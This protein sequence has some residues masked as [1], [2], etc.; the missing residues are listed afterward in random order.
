MCKGNYEFVFLHR[1][2]TFNAEAISRSRGSGL[3]ED[4]ISP[5]DKKARE[6]LD[7]LHQWCLRFAGPKEKA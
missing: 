6:K 3:P 1:H 7:E 2:T 5:A 4:E